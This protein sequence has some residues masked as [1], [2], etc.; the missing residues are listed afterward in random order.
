MTKQGAYM[1]EEDIRKILIGIATLETK[2]DATNLHLATL[3]GSVKTLYGRADANKESIHKATE[4]LLEHQIGCT[5]LGEI[6]EI[7][8]KLDSG[9]FHGSREVHDELIE[10]AERVEKIKVEESVKDK[11]SNAWKHDLLIPMVR[12]CVIGLVLLILLHAGELL[13]I[14]K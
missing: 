1:I 12:F 11:I 13:K 2:V 8:R 7:N 3:N 4:A 5:A 9:D 6:R 10:T 14:I